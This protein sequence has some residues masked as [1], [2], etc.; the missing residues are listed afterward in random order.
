MGEM[1][2]LFF[3]VQEVSDK[4]NKSVI[5]IKSLRAGKILYHFSSFVTR[6]ACGPVQL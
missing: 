4:L 5:C 1:G 3:S 6:K 2:S